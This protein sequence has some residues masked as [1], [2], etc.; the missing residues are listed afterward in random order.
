MRSPPYAQIEL[1]P[2]R[3]CRAWAMAIALLLIALCALSIRAEGHFSF[4]ITLWL[5]CCAGVIAWL[6]HDAWRQRSGQLQYSQGQW[7]WQNEASGVAGTLRV[8]LD[9]QSYILV[10]FTE[11][12]RNRPFLSPTTTWF[13]LEARHAAPAFGPASWQAVRRAVYASAGPEHEAVAA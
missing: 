11:Q 9:L 10:S 7:F 1:G 4:K 8:H 3:V 12:H 2:S 5:A 13:H 6:L